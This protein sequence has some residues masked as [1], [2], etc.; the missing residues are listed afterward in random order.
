M[1]I[2]LAILPTQACLSPRGQHTVHR[3]IAAP[4]IFGCTIL[5]NLRFIR[6]L[7]QINGDGAI[8]E[9]SCAI[10]WTEQSVSVITHEIWHGRLVRESL[11][12]RVKVEL[13]DGWD[14]LLSGD[15]SLV[16]YEELRR[17][18]GEKLR[19]FHEAA[20]IKA[21]VARNGGG[22]GEEESSSVAPPKSVRRKAVQKEDP[23]RTLI[24][25]GSWSHT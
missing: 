14:S 15:A 21:R 13:V 19:S 24:F 25:L 4:Q 23:I 11:L 16:V 1:I 5:L 9:A 6:Q 20:I 12:S 7:N 10:I 2:P 17:V 3:T 22:G 18:M 8:I